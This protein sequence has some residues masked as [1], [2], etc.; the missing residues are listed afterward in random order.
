METRGA[1]RDLGISWCVQSSPLPLICRSPET[2]SADRRCLV[3]RWLPRH[4]R[5]GRSK[6]GAVPGEIMTAAHPSS[7]EK[8]LA[9]RATGM[10]ESIIPCPEI[11]GPRC[12]HKPPRSCS[13]LPRHREPTAKVRPVWVLT[14]R[15]D[16]IDTWGE[17]SSPRRGDLRDPF[18]CCFLVGCSWWLRDHAEALRA[19]RPRSLRRELPLETPM[20]SSSCDSRYAPEPVSLMHVSRSGWTS[21]CD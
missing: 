5:R 8:M 12:A 6:V 17:R 14:L 16:Y 3:S 19:R 13:T 18:S 10:A 9:P 21:S 15:G 11:H 20:R 2:A 1:S 7:S 4:G